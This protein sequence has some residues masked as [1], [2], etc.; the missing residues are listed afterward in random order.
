MEIEF[1]GKKY[2]YDTKENLTILEF[3]KKKNESLDYQ[4][5]S[6]FCGACRCKIDSGKI[7]ESPDAIGFKNQD[8]I[9]PC[10]SKPKSN[11]KIRRI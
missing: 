9:L 2:E 10:V 8:E 1:D 7:E 5:Q 6:G 4:C 3:L 11:I